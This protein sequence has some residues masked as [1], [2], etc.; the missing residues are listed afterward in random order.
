MLFQMSARRAAIQVMGVVDRPYSVRNLRGIAETCPPHERI[1]GCGDEAFIR[2][3]IAAERRDK[4]LSDNKIAEILSDQGIQV[5]AE[6]SPSTARQW[7]SHP[8]TS[9]SA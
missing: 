2:K 7:E 4:P 8:R 1:P 6:P 3:L 9:A 5:H